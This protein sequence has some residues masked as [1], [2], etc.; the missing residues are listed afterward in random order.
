M[1]GNINEIETDSL[2]SKAIVSK[3]YK[4]GRIQVLTGH[5]AKRYSRRAPYDG[6]T[7]QICM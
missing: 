5:E 3:N 6:I 7:A 4:L 2:D 1:N